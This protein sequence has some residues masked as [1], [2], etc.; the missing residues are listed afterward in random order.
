MDSC[1]DDDCLFAE[2]AVGL[3][4]CDSE[5]VY[6]ISGECFREGCSSDEGCLGVIIF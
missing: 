5:E 2:K 3:R 4:V 1:A 6:L